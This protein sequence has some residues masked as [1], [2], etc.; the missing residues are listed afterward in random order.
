MPH[1]T[2]LRFSTRLILILMVLRTAL[3]LAAGSPQEPPGKLKDWSFGY[4]YVHLTTTA[5]NTY[6]IH[7][8]A[9]SYHTRNGWRTPLVTSTSLLVPAGIRYN[10]DFDSG[11]FDYYTRTLGIDFA[12]GVEFGSFPGESWRWRTAPGWNL[13][14]FSLPGRTGYYP[15]QSIT[16]G[17]ALNLRMGLSASW[18]VI[19]LIHSADRLKNG[20]SLQFHAGIGFRDGSAFGRIDYE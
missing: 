9:V 15:F 19:D 13:I 2:S 8:P 4:S 18:Q 5:G 6:D 1:P 17:T 14:A 16:T 3:P 11:L 10:D 7:S 20:F 12:P